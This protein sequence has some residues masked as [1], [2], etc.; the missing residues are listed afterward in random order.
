MAGGTFNSRGESYIVRIRSNELLRV[1]VTGNFSADLVL[2]RSVDDQKSW[3]HVRSITSAVD[4]TVP[5][6]NE[7]VND[8][9]NRPADD[10]IPKDQATK[11]QLAKEQAD[12]EARKT[13]AQTGDE[14]LE[15]PEA[16]EAFYRLRCTAHRNGTVS[17]LLASVDRPVTEREARKYRDDMDK[18]VA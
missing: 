6:I 15:G 12:A 1:N 10:T 11:E 13:A 8:D 14:P 4:F 7:F 16:V 17:Y 9:Q 5:D 18:K 2:E 3:E